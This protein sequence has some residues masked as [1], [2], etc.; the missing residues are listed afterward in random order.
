MFLVITKDTVLL[1]AMMNLIGKESVLHVRHASDICPT[2]H[3][4][5]QVIIDT[6]DNNLFYSEMAQKL[7]SLQ[8]SRVLI[9]SPFR[10]KKCLGNIPV[11]FIARNIALLDFVALLNNRV[12]YRSSPALS[13]SRK[14]HQVLTCILQQKP[15]EE[16]V[17]ELNISPKTFYC[18]KYNVMLLL[19]LRKMRDLVRHQFSRYLV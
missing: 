5:A 16:I 6:L 1:G 12:R 17:E 13:L 19:K 3:Q 10:I 7:E 4:H 8:P 9:F 11:T 15:C 2:R 18:H 14:Q